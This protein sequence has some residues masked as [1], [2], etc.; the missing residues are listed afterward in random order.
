MRSRFIAMGW[1]LPLVMTWV[2]ILSGCPS[3]PPETGPTA[4]FNASPATGNAPLAVSF[5]DTST[6]GSAAIT[7]WSWNFGDGNTSTSQN[8]AHTYADA[9]TYTVSLTVTTSVGSDTTTINNMITVHAAGEDIAPEAAFEVD[10]DSGLAPLLVSFTDTS[11]AGSAAITSWSWNFGDGNTSTSQNPAHTYA[12]AGTYTVSLTVTTSVGSDTVTETDFISVEAPPVGLN[13]LRVHIEPTKDKIESGESLTFKI[14]VSNRGALPLTNIQ[15]TAEVPGGLS[16]FTQPTGGT[17]PGGV[18]NSG[19]TITWEIGTLLAG[20]SRTVLFSANVQTGTSAPAAGFQLVSGVVA[21]AAPNLTDTASAT[22]IVEAPKRIKS[23]IHI[24]RREAQPGDILTYTVSYGNSLDETLTDATIRTTIPENTTLIR[25][26]SQGTVED[27][28]VVWALGDVPI[29]ASGQ[30]QMLVEVQNNAEIGAVLNSTVTFSGDTL[31]ETSTITSRT[32]AVVVGGPRLAVDYSVSENVVTPGMPVI[33]T[34]TATNLGN[35]ALQDVQLL[36]LTPESVQNFSN[37]DFGSCPGGVCNSHEL[38]TFNLGILPVGESRSVHFTTLIRTGSTAPDG[39]SII[40]GIVLASAQGNVFASAEQ[41]IVVSTDER[42]TASI[43]TDASKVMPGDVLTYVL[44]YG[45]AMQASLEDA[46]LTMWLPENTSLVDATGNPVVTDG[47]LVWDISGILTGESEI[48]R[49][50]VLVD[51][52]AEVNS[53]LWANVQFEGETLFKRGHTLAST[54]SI[55]TAEPQMALVVDV[56]ETVISHGDTLLYRFT[57]Q[58]LT[59]NTQRDVRLTVGVPEGVN[60]FSNPNGGSCPGGVCNSYETLVFNLGTLPAGDIKSVNFITTVRTGSTA[61]ASASLIYTPVSVT[62]EGGRSASSANLVSVNTLDKISV[63]IAAT[64]VQVVSGNQIE[65]EITYANGLNAAVSNGQL[66]TWLPIDTTFVSASNGGFQEGAVVTWNVS[67]L[68]VGKAG[69][70]S[71]VVAVPENT[72]LNSVFTGEVEFVAN[73]SVDYSRA[74]GRTQSVARSQKALTIEMET[75]QTIVRSG[76][77]ILHTIR[78]ENTTESL[79]RD[80]R[81]VVIV[82]NGVS[83]FSQPTGGIC[84]GGVC[85]SFENIIWEIG[86]IVA[87]GTEIFTF[88]TSIRT[89][90]TAPSHGTLIVSS[91]RVTGEDVEGDSSQRVMIV[92]TP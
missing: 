50:T 2:L 67:G 7:S 73:T 47:N 79:I 88:T 27:G 24:D 40:S 38:I 31:L 36:A 51:E 56:N 4:A 80:A 71:F 9:G 77:A 34:I 23:N 62:A 59:E 10:I 81:L 44:A 82:P 63:G 12:D 43:S 26:S 30:E 86:D 17:C 53:V 29:G 66:T 32:K 64:P 91:A 49:V 92:E 54:H 72:P 60:N 75:S 57:V 61:P 84:P 14:S 28:Q 85:N 18:C 52:D 41:A 6:A 22:V 69:V 42:L 76:D 21:S 19:E 16:N 1:V 33:H 74:W 37:P 48:Q 13:P 25:S 70:Q 58:N 3:S 65:F 11:T 78:V 83:N 90:S 35:N 20:R 87:G 5:S 15:L 46:A 39:G 8:P 45:N 68:P 89:G 55:V